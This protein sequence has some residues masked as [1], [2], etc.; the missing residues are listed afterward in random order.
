MFARNRRG[1]QRAAIARALR[2]ACGVNAVARTCGITAGRAAKGRAF[3]FPAPI[4]A[5]EN[6]EISLH[7]TRVRKF[8][9]VGHDRLNPAC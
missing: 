2:E 6:L 9:V 1:G 8:R 3:P 7:W 4:A 5:A